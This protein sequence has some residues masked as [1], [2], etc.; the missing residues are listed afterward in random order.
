RSAASWRCRR[1]RHW[2]SP[3]E[4]RRALRRPV[5]RAACKGPAEPHRRWSIRPPFGVRRRLY[6]VLGRKPAS[7][8]ATLQARSS[9]GNFIDR[10]GI[11]M[12]GTQRADQVEAGALP[13]AGVLVAE[14]CNVAAGPFCGMLLA[15]MGAEIVKIE[16]PDG[17]MLRHW[18]PHTG[19]FSENFASL[20]RGKRSIALDLKD[21]HDREIAWDIMAKA[22]VVIENNRPGVM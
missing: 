18:P 1:R 8:G 5:R 17:D 15:D 16:P 11:C 4:P 21:P 20:N 12:A 2:S 6:C 7:R 9:F 10:T 13:L 19:G 22:A 14:F 3:Q